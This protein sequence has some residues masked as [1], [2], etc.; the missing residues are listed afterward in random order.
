MN[1]LAKLAGVSQSLVSLVLNGKAEG[2]ISKKRQ[3]EI[4]TLARKHNFRINPAAKKLRSG[5]KNLIGIAMPV[6]SVPSYAVRIVNL[7]NMLNQLNYYV[8]FG[9]WK[10]VQEIPDTINEIISLG[11]DALISWDYHS[12]LKKE[13]IPIVL[14]E[15]Q[16]SDYDCASIDFYD[17]VDK[18]IKYVLEL[19]HRKVGFIG[20]CGTDSPSLRFNHL[21]KQ[22]PL[23]GIEMRPEWIKDAQGKLQAGYD[24]FG[25]IMQC[26]EKPTLLIAHNDIIAQGAYYRAQE[27]GIKIPEDISI[28]GGDNMDVC[29]FLTPKLDSFS[30][31]ETKMDAALVELIIERLKNPDAP[32]KNVRIEVNLVKRESCRMI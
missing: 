3:N 4:L 22:L 23:H 25:E 27:L 26:K 24:R 19:N 6:P 30:I 2:R 9:F 10:N 21:L 1:E 5:E 20:N 8:V 12:C 16:T 28:I 18:L 32:C 29:D 15:Q 13:H 17:Y 7:Q 31:N 14:Y 11:V